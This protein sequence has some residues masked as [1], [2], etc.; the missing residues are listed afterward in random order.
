MTVALCLNCG[1]LKVGA[2]SRCPHCSFEPETDEDIT[3]SLMMSDHHFNVELLKEAGEKIKRGEKLEFDEQTLKDMWVTK[4]Q[5]KEGTK[6][7]W[8]RLFGCLCKWLLAFVAILSA[9]LYLILR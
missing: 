2:F 8:R 6:V 7:A 3:K 1:G 5:V 4:E 9:A